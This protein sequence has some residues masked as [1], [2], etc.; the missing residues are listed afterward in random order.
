MAYCTILDVARTGGFFKL[1]LNEA[2]G[3]GDGSAK[4]FSLDNGN[5][6]ED[7]ET[8][9]VGG[10][11]KSRITDYTIDNGTGVVTFNSPAAQNKA[12]TGTYKY[13][14]DPIALTNGDIT[15]FISDADSEIDSLTGK[16]WDSSTEKTEY[17]EGRSEKVS[18]ETGVDTDSGQ[19]HTETQYE[20]YTLLLSKRPVVSITSVQFLEDDGTVDDTLVE[21]EEYWWWE[22]GRIRLSSAI[23][24]GEGKQK[25]KVIYNYG[26]ASVPRDVK[27]LSSCMAAIMA[28]VSLTGGSYDKADSY[29]LGPVSASLGGA[30]A[31]FKE[32]IA[33]LESRK[34]DLLGN[35]GKEIRSVVV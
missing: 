16:S 32:T 13:I 15:E 34:N 23:P 22:D 12:V 33:M 18:A 21:N 20:K 3:T 24:A 19:Y 5:V 1:S 27:N 17:F 29:T 26:A 25:V 2:I 31:D 14:P 10:S 9:Y 30:S 7:S 8:I 11:E 28:F 35:I 6:I 4:I